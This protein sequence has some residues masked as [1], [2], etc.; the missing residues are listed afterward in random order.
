MDCRMQFYFLNSDL[1]ENRTG[2]EN[3]SLLRAKLFSRYLGVDPVIATAS[4]HPRLN[5]QRE[6]LYESGLLSTNSK[7][8][9]MYEFFQG[10]PDSAALYGEWHRNETWKYDPVQGTKDYRISNE[11]DKLLLYRK[12]DKEGRLIYDNVFVNRK[13]VRRD[14]YDSNGCLS[15]MQFLDPEDGET[16]CET[17]YRAD[18]T[19]CIYKYYE[20]KEGK[21]HLIGLHLMNRE[22]QLIEP[23]SSEQELITYW[24]SML[25]E[26][27]KLNFFIVD[28]EKVYY[29]SLSELKY[30]NLFKICMIHSS[31]LQKDA[32]KLNGRLNSNYK[33][34]FEDLSRIDALVVFTNRQKSDI[35]KRFGSH[36]HIQVIPHAIDKEISK[37]EFN[38]RVPRQAVYLARYSVEKQHDS[39]I[40]IFE[41]VVNQY[42]DAKLQLYG[43]GSLKD[44]LIRQIKA[45]GLERNIF[46]NNFTDQIEAIYNSASLSILT[47]RVEGFSLFLLESLAHGCPVISF[48]IDY[49]PSDMIQDGIN[50]YLVECFNEEAMAEKIISLFSNQSRLMEMSEASYRKA[51]EFSPEQIASKWIVLIS[52]LLKS[53]NIESGIQSKVVVE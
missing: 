13:K 17:Y 38:S 21:N 12:C 48:D 37:V 33:D 25:I 51:D 32:E 29:S 41:K 6:K 22:G 20:K 43:Y 4:Y 50:G 47:S 9:N 27:N 23:F 39:L 14:T 31:H 46:L 3:S 5:L 18:G 42:P 36:D 19:V 52:Q 53:R 26:E 45:A 2:V 15:R 30:P 24:L 49:G 34:I 7:I 11:K 28:K 8:I 44:E 16:Q 10:I 40:R 35:E 1:G